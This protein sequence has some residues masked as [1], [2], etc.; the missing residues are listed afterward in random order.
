MYFWRGMWRHFFSHSFLLGLQYLDTYFRIIIMMKRGISF[1]LY[2]F[3]DEYSL[4]RFVPHT[5]FGLHLQNRNL[6]V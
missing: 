6:Y 1:F 3:I 4:I 2:K 5:A